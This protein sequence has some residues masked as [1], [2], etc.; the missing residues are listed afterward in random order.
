MLGCFVW[1]SSEVIDGGVSQVS[2]AVILVLLDDSPKSISVS[3]GLGTAGRGAFDWSE[4]VGVNTE[5]KFF[6]R[7]LQSGS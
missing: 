7:T 3:V 2:A 1:N 5:S 4:V 6:R